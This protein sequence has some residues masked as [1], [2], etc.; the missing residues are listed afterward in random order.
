MRAS[1]VLASVIAVA[2]ISTFGCSKSG[3]NNATDEVGTTS[4]TFAPVA[5]VSGDSDQQITR[6]VESS[7]AADPFVSRAARNVEVSAVDGIV[8]L[9]GPVDNIPTKWTLESMAKRVN[10]V[11]EVLDKTTIAPAENTIESADDQISYDLQRALAFDPAVA[12]DG[13]S[14]SID[15]VK[16]IVTLRGSTRDDATEEAV[17]R[18]AEQTPGVIAVKDRL[19][20][21]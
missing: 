17:Q 3:D 9:T 16:G 8:T 6:R 7:F 5:V 1:L 15:V 4:L 12:H 21:R 18:I 13:E 2:G 20:V 11:D 14:V 19:A 10:G